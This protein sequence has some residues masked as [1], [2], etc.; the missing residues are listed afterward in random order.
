[1]LRGV[2]LSA[3]FVLIVPAGPRVCHPLPDNWVA[4]SVAKPRAALCA[5][6]AHATTTRLNGTDLRQL[7]SNSPG[8]CLGYIRAVADLL[9]RSG[10]HTPTDLEAVAITI[11]YLRDNPDELDND[12]VSLIRLA[13]EKAAGCGWRPLGKWEALGD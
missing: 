6:P 8:Q 13:L 11:R 1:M 5:E 7:C 9:H 4:K 10:C 2:D 12:A 3:L